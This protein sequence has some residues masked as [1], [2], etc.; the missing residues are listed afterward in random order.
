MRGHRWDT[1]TS[2][3]AQSK[4]GSSL[5]WASTG[6]ERRGNRVLEANQA[7]NTWKTICKTKLQ[8]RAQ[9][10]DGNRTNTTWGDNT[11]KVKT[12]NTPSS[13]VG[14]I[15][16]NNCRKV[17]V[18]MWQACGF[19]NIWIWWS[20]KHKNRKQEARAQHV[21]WE[22]IRKKSRTAEMHWKKPLGGALEPE[23]YGGYLANF[24]L[25]FCKNY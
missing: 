1:K 23:K 9:E 25:R 17:R 18:G 19:K 6:K 11:N 13:A 24:K 10:T 2:M 7:N 20:G 21:A 22:W 3:A 5:E 16:K 14:Q 8:E 15:K 4:T 12:K